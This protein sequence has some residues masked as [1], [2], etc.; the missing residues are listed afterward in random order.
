MKLTGCF[1]CILV[2]FCQLLTFVTSHSTLEEAQQIHHSPAKKYR[3]KLR[4]EEGAIRLVNGANDYE[5]ERMH[6][7][8]FIGTS[9]FNL[10]W[11]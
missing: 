11:S 9:S 10:F 4:K 1:W 3:K 7:K 2:I 6:L 8:F 5:G